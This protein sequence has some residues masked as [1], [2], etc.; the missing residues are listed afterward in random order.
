M[1][2]RTPERGGLKALRI[3]RRHPTKSDC[4]KPD[5]TLASPPRCGVER[6]V[7]YTTGTDVASP[8]WSR[9]PLREGGF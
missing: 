7:R 1:G 5:L 8:G 6:S 2:L 4:P 3:L 9:V